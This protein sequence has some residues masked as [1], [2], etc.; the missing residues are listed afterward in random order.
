MDSACRRVSHALQDWYRSATGEWGSVM[1]WRSAAGAYACPAG[2]AGS[3]AIAHTV[4]SSA[5]VS[6]VTCKV[7]RAS[8]TSFQR[9]SGPFIEAGQAGLMHTL[10]KTLKSCQL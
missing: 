5:P 10:L 8:S 2:P 4:G 1:R 7:V 9:L 3:R 6:R